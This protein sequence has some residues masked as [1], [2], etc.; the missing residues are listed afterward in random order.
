MT[1]SL[2]RRR[3]FLQLLGGLLAACSSDAVATAPEGAAGAA[4][5]AGGSAGEAGAAGG[6]PAPT[7][8]YGAVWDI[9]ADLEQAVAASPDNLPAIA[10]GLVAASD[11]RGLFA[12]VRDRIS[13]VPF[14]DYATPGYQNDPARLAF[15]PRATLRSGAGSPRDKVQ[16]LRDLLAEAGLDARVVVT[17]YAPAD[18]E[19]IAH[20]TRKVHPALSVEVEPGKIDGWLERFQLSREQAPSEGPALVDPTG[21]EAA[22]LADALLAQLPSPADASE[23]MPVWVGPTPA[24]QV[25]IGG[26]VHVLQPLRPDA[27]FDEAYGELVGDAPEATS[28]PVVLAVEGIWSDDLQWAPLVEGTW[29]EHELAGRQ[30]SFSAMPLLPPEVL[31]RS[32]IDEPVTFRPLLGLQATDDPKAPLPADRAFVGDG[33]SLGGDVLVTTPAGEVEINGRRLASPGEKGPVEKVASLEVIASALRFPRVEVRV[34]ALDSAGA[35]VLGLGSAAFDVREGEA[36]RSALL[37]ANTAAR[38]ALILIDGSGSMPAAFLGDGATELLAQIRA[39][40]LAIDPTFEIAT[41]VTESDIWT[42]LATGAD[43]DPGAIVFITDGDVTDSKTA[44]IEAVLKRGP[45]ACLI[46]VT[47]DLSEQLVEMATLTGGE[48]ALVADP[49]EARDRAVKFLK[50]TP[51][52]AYLLTYDAPLAGPVDREVTVRVG[53]QKGAGTYRVP[54][55]EER[56]PARRLLGLRLAATMGGV[57][58]QR[59]LFGYDTSRKDTPTAEEIDSLG[60]ALRIELRSA[61]VLSF[62]GESPLP[63]ALASQALTMFSSFRPLLEAVEAGDEKSL[64][65]A[66]RADRP[67]FPGSLLP[68]RARAPNA[69]AASTFAGGL[70]LTVHGSRLSLSEQGASTTNITDVF[71]IPRHRS[72]GAMTPEEA[73]RATAR[74]TVHSALVEARTHKTSTV[75]ELAGKPLAAALPGEVPEVPAG[76]SPAESARL[77]HLLARHIDAYRL[78]ASDGS[79]SAMWVIDART[80]ETFAL[81]GDGSGGSEEVEAYKKQLAQLQTLLDVISIFSTIFGASSLGLAVSYAQFQVALWAAATV[82]V[83]S[84][85]GSGAEGELANAMLGAVQTAIGE[86]IGGPFG[87]AFSILCFVLGKA[88]A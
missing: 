68:M 56:L 41:S 25:T 87:A 14:T 80:G 73:F 27:S 84:L 47:A 1:S 35:P 62:D 81:L 75:S 65:A 86:L 5:S 12:L 74:A 45:R 61:V 10:A 33:F 88:T 67:Q 70:G 63:A 51:P 76:M 31:L 44:A 57:T 30:V 21:S 13:T 48:A 15:G 18:S 79:S 60:E 26:K 66:I 28:S 20:F 83:L 77:A 34:K 17:D 53:A 40:L 59:S 6:A 7:S 16:L 23:A 38:R 69:L 72:V 82:S 19:V 49:G 43:G 29:P 2:V 42:S 54:V 52:P 85:D 24:V 11:A 22:A 9:V 39:D 50:E 32:N 8:R 71:T 37:R 46:D 55:A 58:R 36:G 4:G 64:N 78:Y 3:G